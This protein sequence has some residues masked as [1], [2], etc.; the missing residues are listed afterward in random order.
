MME[1]TAEPVVDKGRV[2]QGR[3]CVA[4]R[5]TAPR[6]ELLR[7]VRSP[8]GGLVIDWRGNLAGR[9]A[10][11]CP[12][13]RCF[14]IAF[15]KRRFDRGLGP[16][17]R[18]PAAEEMLASARHATMR[19]IETLLRSATGARA[20]AAGSEACERAFAEGRALTLLLAKDAAA[21][22]RLV[23][24][25][26][27]GGVPVYTM[28]SKEVLGAMAGRPATGALAALDAGLARALA[29]ACAR[30]VAMS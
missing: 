29:K 11:V 1:R 7:V 22:E 18:Y 27:Q 12:N 17:E 15:G 4:C 19:Q 10:H 21:R 30:L 16:V 20:L 23:A 5:R 14:E 2:R 26:S 3:T 28:D 24:R 6:A 9:G 8:E 13:R 25:A